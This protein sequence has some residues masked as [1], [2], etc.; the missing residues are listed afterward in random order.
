MMNVGLCPISDVITFVLKLTSPKLKFCSRKGALGFLF[1]QIWPMFG[2]V[3]RFSHLKTA[4][5]WFGVLHGLRVFSNSVS[6]IRFSSTMM[7]VFRVFLSS[8]FYVFSGFAKEGTSPSC[9]KTGVIPNTIYIA[10][11]TSFYRNG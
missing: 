8:A 7:A 6:G 11:H 9:T 5:F 3:F 10:F 4:V 2:S 1:L